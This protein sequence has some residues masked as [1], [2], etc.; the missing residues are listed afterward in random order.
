MHNS[1]M[2]RVRLQHARS[3]VLDTPPSI[4]SKQQFHEL[5][6]D[7]DILIPGM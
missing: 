5:P 6:D 1:R 3:D 2:N 7:P 4:R